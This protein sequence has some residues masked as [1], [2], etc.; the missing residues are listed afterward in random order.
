MHLDQNQLA[1]LAAILRLGSFEAAAAELAVTASAI[2]QRLKA[3]EDRVGSALIIRAQPCQGTETGR[4]LA[5]H[6]ETLRLL[7][8]QLGR[9]LKTTSPDSP[10]PRLRLAVNADSLATW[11]IAPLAS[12]KDVLFDLIIDDQEH[13]A[14]WLMRAEV[15]GAVTAH[16]RPVAGCDSY[17][18]G[19]LRYIATASPA[20]LAQWCPNGPDANSLCNAPML[21]F[22]QKDRL[23]HQWLQR[24]FDLPHLPPS[25]SLPSTQGFID[26]ALVGL[27]W[28]MNPEQLVKPHLKA[29][30]L[31]A[32]KPQASLDI[33]LFWQV[34]RITA[35]A[36]Q[37]L[38]R[39]IRRRAKTMLVQ[40]ISG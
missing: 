31:V 36:L 40:P 35:P 2:S 28:G 34:S 9:D 8:H 26:A 37:D 6:A 4:R 1:A 32:V 13:S 15:V 12:R 22:D 39:A 5:A 10:S 29:G 18:L 11:F 19:A 30:R 16:S 25:H 24:H 27:G 33:P 23:Q 38:T 7:E 17:A 21:C 14:D 20:F 3:L